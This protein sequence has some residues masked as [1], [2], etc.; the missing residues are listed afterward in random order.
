MAKNF[1]KSAEMLSVR[2][3]SLVNMTLEELQKAFKPEFGNQ[4][5]I[6]IF[7]LSKKIAR[8]KELARKTRSVKTKLT[9]AMWDWYHTQGTLVVMRNGK[10]HRF[11]KVFGQAEELAR[12]LLEE[13]VYKAN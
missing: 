1:I 2:F 6:H 9:K 12:F 10:C 13:Q 7:E 3:K 11:G 5:H 8:K 4:N